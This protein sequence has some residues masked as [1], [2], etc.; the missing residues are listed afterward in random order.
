MIAE[1]AGKISTGGEHDMKKDCRL[2]QQCSKKEQA[3][4][5][6]SR[7]LDAKIQLQN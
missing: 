6:F 2:D 7:E 5:D 1:S 4:L 3:N